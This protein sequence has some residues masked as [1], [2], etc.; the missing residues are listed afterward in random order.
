[1]SSIKP[2]S[3]DII[4]LQKFILDPLSTV[5]KLAVLGKKN[6]GC[7][8]SIINNQIYIQENGMFQGV[9]R[10]YQGVSKN[11]IH[12]LSTPIEIACKKY[13]THEKIKEI[14]NIRTIFKCSQQGLNNLMETYN[15]YPIIVHCLKYY[16]TIIDNYLHLIS[17]EIPKVLL[18]PE[19]VTYKK[20]NEIKI[21]NK[22]K[23]KERNSESSNDYQTPPI[24][25]NDFLAEHVEDKKE[26]I[27]EISNPDEQPKKSLDFSDNELLSLYTDDLLNKFNLI[28][29]KSKIEIVINMID[30]L[31]IEKSASEYAAYIETF[32]IPIDKEILKI[33]YQ[34]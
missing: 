30:Y 29:E 14:P 18:I 32:M 31:A 27:S 8:I 20:I 15:I 16:H 17:C 23:N 33:I 22:S 10:Y 1:M 13:L 7:K 28:W 34:E 19:Q 4:T 24:I 21:P 9:A 3:N 5:I 26:S 11:D 6:I 2:Q 12:Y 25:N